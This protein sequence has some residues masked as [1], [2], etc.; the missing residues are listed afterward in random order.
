M[1][2]PSVYSF[3]LAPV[4][5]LIGGCSLEPPGNE[6]KPPSLS[7]CT[8]ETNSSLTTYDQMVAEFLDQET[9]HPTTNLGGQVVWNAR[10][11]LESLI[12][13][14]QA[15]RNPKYLSAFEDTGG[16]VIG[17]VQTIQQLDIPDPSAPGKF[18]N[19]PYIS[20]TGWPTWMATYGAPISIPTQTGTVALYAQSLYPRDSTG[21]SFVDIT[22]Q[23]D[24]S[25]Q[26]A[27]S[28]AGKDLKSYAINSASDLY[29]IASQPLTYGQSIGRIY[30]TGLGLPA[31]GSYELD[32]P[33][34]TVWDGEQTGG[35]LLP[36]VRFLLIAKAHPDLVD[37]DLASEWTSEVEQIA[38]SYVDQFA[39]DG[40]SGYYILNPSWMPMTDAGLPAPSD[41]VF[42]E[43]SLRI[44]LYKLTGDANQ[45]QYAAG[46]LRHQMADDIPTS[47]R[48]FL[49]VREWPDIRSWSNKSQAPAGSIWDSLTYDSTAGENTSEAAAF[50]Q[51]LY[52][53][54]YYGLAQTLGISDSFLQ[55]QYSTFNQYVDIPDAQALGFPSSVRSAYPTG[56]SSASDSYD[57][58]L[59]PVAAAG[60]LRPDSSN[61]AYWLANWQWMAYAGS[62]PA[63]N[64]IGYF[65]RAWARSE[66]ALL[67]ACGRQ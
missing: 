39:S 17:L 59:D 52:L 13:A 34:V 19:G 5:L 32:T 44:L 2:K 35:I 50:V 51:M 23:P 65:L 54:D 47:S 46:L 66:A 63:G 58:S 64:P 29:T 42:V 43:I 11:Y 15:T 21:A 61:S 41:Y 62:N 55:A 53:A 26:F 38:N 12:T 8:A 37:P 27:W 24:G 36:F 14:Y 4:L 20:V 30:P 10:Y 57:P 60:F 49:L 3:L 56:Q 45:L 28:R 1:G 22:Q 48:G 18:A 67:S 31:P 25:L 7:A 40:N 16:A 9:S 33:L 6:A